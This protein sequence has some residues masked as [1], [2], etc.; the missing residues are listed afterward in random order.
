[1]PTSIPPPSWLEGSSRTLRRRSR[2]P[3]DARQALSNFLAI[4]HE[5]NAG[6]QHIVRM[7]CYL[8]SRD[9]YAARASEI[10]AA[11]R[12]VMARN[13]TV[14]YSSL[15]GSSGMLNVDTPMLLYAVGWSAETA[16][17]PQIGSTTTRR[18]GSISWIAYASLG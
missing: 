6:P 15:P 12:E 5:A 13:E 2:S 17:L 11:Y 18:S 1:M 8:P 4:L 16:A 3:A 9:E 14:H 7:T 10:G